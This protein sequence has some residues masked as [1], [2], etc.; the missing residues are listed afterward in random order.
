M[1]LLAYWRLIIH[2]VLFYKIASDL[3]LRKRISNMIELLYNNKFFIKSNF[4]Y[5]S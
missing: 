3:N 2:L 4:V 5:C 1:K